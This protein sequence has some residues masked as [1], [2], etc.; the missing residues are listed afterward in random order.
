MNSRVPLVLISLNHAHLHSSYNN[1]CNKYHWN[2]ISKYW[3]YKM[4]P[5]EPIGSCVL[6]V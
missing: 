1:L 4:A 6:P 5:N 3:V 2:E